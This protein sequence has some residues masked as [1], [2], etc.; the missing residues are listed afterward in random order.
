MTTRRKC[1][2]RTVEKLHMLPHLEQALGR[3][4]YELDLVSPYF[5]PGKDGTAWLKEHCERGVKV[6]V[7][8]NS[9]AATDVGVVHAGYSRYRERLLR[10]GVRLY[11]QKP[12]SESEGARKDVER[13]GIG[14]S[15]TS[16][17]AKTFS[18]DR[19]RIFVG[20]FNLDPRS[21]RLNTEM[22]VIIASPALAE[23][24]S[25]VRYGNSGD[26]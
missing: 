26:A 20:S 2:K 19:S 15:A 24:L 1:C 14:D 12:E 7:L 5:V 9:L 25:T 13:H 18:V 23:R 4:M 6:R 21:D 16:V 17:H 3:P 8:T 22:G 10:A 11:E